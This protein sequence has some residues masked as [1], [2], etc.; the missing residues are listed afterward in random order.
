MLSGHIY[1]RRTY[2][3]TLS[4]QFLT[5]TQIKNIAYE[6]VVTVYYSAAD[7]WP[8]NPADQAISASYDSS[9]SG[10][11]FETWT[12]RLLEVF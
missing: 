3:E 9:I 6:K 8:A 12:V 5:K 7:V 1:V 4:H 2:F 10:S 11:N